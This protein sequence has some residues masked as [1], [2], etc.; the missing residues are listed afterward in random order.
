M[1]SHHRDRQNRK[2]SPLERFGVPRD[3]TLPSDAGAFRPPGRSAD[4]HVTT[5]SSSSSSQSQEARTGRSAATS[6]RS[7]SKEPG[8]SSSSSSSST[9][10][11]SAEERLRQ[12]E[13]EREIAEHARK[14]PLCTMATTGTAAASTVS[15]PASSSRISPSSASSRPRASDLLRHNIE[16]PPPGH[17]V[18]LRAQGVGANHAAGPPEQTVAGGGVIG[19]GVHEVQESCEFLRRIERTESFYERIPFSAKDLSNRVFLNSLLDLK[20]G[21]GHLVAEQSDRVLPARPGGSP[22]SSSS[23]ASPVARLAAAADPVCGGR[24]RSGEDREEDG[25][26]AGAPQLRRTTSAGRAER[27]GE[28]QDASSAGMADEDY[29]TI[30]E[31]ESPVNLDRLVSSDRM[32]TPIA[33]RDDGSSRAAGEQAP[34]ARH[35]GGSPDDGRENPEETGADRKKAEKGA[36]LAK[37]AKKPDDSGLKSGQKEL[38]R[39]STV[40]NDIKAAEV[41]KEETT[42]EQEMKDDVGAAVEYEDA[43][44]EPVLEQEIHRQLNRMNLASEQLNQS[45]LK[46]KQLHDS[47]DGLTA[48]WAL[49]RVWLLSSCKE[50]NVLLAEEYYLLDNDLEKSKQRTKALS[51]KFSRL[52]VLVGAKTTEKTVS[53]AQK[54]EQLLAQEI[55]TGTALQK[56]LQHM[57]KPMGGDHGSKGGSAA[58]SLKSAKKLAAAVE[59][60][61]PF[62]LAYRH[63]CQSWKEMK[64]ELETEGKNSR[65]HK[66]TYHDA[67]SKLEKISAEEHAKRL[68][69]AVP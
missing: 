32:P 7:A 16:E 62:F 30:P 28:D 27:A 23:P 9:S 24:G 67:I 56:K 18:D 13:L 20:S 21:A 22:S 1:F 37:A 64:G 4:L 33:E 25:R 63:F 15:S 49:Q 26:A 55:A 50:E 47:L 39:E 36:L 12:L 42:Q 40:E 35:D 58:T 61:R 46:Q 31:E 48:D 65:K 10:G 34:A 14:E 19:M 5:I 52:G 6:S 54:I 43:P 44:L 66:D 29:S 59:R 69:S 60:A 68:K 53:K 41:S 2:S 38:H 51:E 17:A 57:L 45:K 11:A 8:A 3:E